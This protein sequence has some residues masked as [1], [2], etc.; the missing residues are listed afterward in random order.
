M[1]KDA[2]LIKAAIKLE[3][4]KSGSSLTELEATL[5]KQAMEKE[6]GG[7]GWGLMLSPDHL[8]QLVGGGANLVGLAAAGVGGLGAIGGFQAYKGLADSDEKLAKKRF[9]ADQYRRATESLM[10]AKM[11]NTL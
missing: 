1:T 3:L 8:T 9:E 11:H 7:A 5:R 4:E 6:A 2:E 10:A